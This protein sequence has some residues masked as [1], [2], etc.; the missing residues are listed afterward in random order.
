MKRKPWFKFDPSAWLNDV[1]LRNCSTSERGV[2]ID[3][4]CI[5]HNNSEYG[6]FLSQYNAEEVKKLAKCLSITERTLNRCLTTLLQMSRICQTIDGQLY[7]KR[8]VQDFEYA[9]KQSDNGKKGG[10]PTLK[11]EKKREEKKREEK[12]A[13][14]EFKTVKFTDK[15]YKSLQS[16]LNSKRLSFGISCL[17][18]YKKS[19][20]KKYECDYAV[21]N[22]GSWLMKR[23]DEEC[24]RSFASV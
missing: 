10:N 12:K 24:P 11:P 18:A 3:L 9:S 15:E 23:I 16:K 6:F 2:L 21:F 7:I 1:E 14:G 5:A 22:K 8:M 20:G 19:S 17:D 4:M 13:F